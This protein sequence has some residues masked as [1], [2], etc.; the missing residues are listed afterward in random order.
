MTTKN[1]IIQ[2]NV[3]CPNCGD[4]ADYYYSAVDRIIRTSCPTC[5]YLMIKCSDT[6]RVIEAYAPGIKS[7][8]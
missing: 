6:G 7:C 4:R 1:N 3:H 5:D 8:A 2:Q